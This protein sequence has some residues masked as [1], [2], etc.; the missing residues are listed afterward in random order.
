MR[1]S[2][3]MMY[4]IPALA[5]LILL[6]GVGHAKAGLVLAAQDLSSA[7]STLQIASSYLPSN[8]SAAAAEFLQSGDYLM[9]AGNRLGVSNFAQAGQELSFA[10]STLQIASSYL[11]S[12]ES[13][14]AAE[15]LQSGD[16]LMGAGNNLASVPEPSP[17]PATMTLLATGLF[18]AGGFGLIWRRRAATA[19]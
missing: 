2:I 18:A 6:L 17:E 3:P 13:A 9:G 14:A 5:T 7:G 19:S 11:P 1:R 15:F 4:S 8:E 16:Y 10:G 12:N